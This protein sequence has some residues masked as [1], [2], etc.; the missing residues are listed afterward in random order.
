MF[1]DAE[2][3]EKPSLEDAAAD[4]QRLT[5]YEKPVFKLQADTLSI[6]QSLAWQWAITFTNSTEMWNSTE[7]IWESA[8]QGYKAT[9]LHEND[10]QLNLEVLVG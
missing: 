7:G 4:K 9:P 10:R 2:T 3:S 8:Q 5:D 6:G 1:V